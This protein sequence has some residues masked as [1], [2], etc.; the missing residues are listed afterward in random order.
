[1]GH[2]HSHG[3][4]INKKNL[5]V[6]TLL[7]FL[8]S[9]AEI[10]GGL[11]SGSLSLLSDAF[12]NLGDAFSTLIAYIASMVSGKKSTPRRTYGYKRI[13]ILAALLNSLL[14]IGITGYLFIEAYERF[15][16]P[17]E[18]NSK[19]M[20]IVAVIGLVANVLAVFLLR[21]DS[22]HNLNV[23]AAYLHLIGDSLSS[24]VVILGGILI[25]FFN[26]Y[27]VDPFITVII[28]I[29]IL[30][31][32]GKIL[33]ETIKILMQN[34]PPELDIETVKNV[35]EN[36]P[37]VNNV[38]HIHAWNLT[39]QKIYFDAHVDTLNDLSLSE[40]NLVRTDLEKILKHDF[41]VYHVTLQFE[42]RTCEDVMIKQKD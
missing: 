32:A 1:M 24:V 42:Y 8:I 15:R 4:E 11:I 16:D 37:R 36:D 25:F 5:L 18:I 2:N 38:H 13:E 9:I 30:Y 39:D 23:R 14:L 6:A 7:N 35:L 10:I 40:V 17:Q 3:H 26:I 20:L 41:D 27:W 33:N 34:T 19:I 12:H 29:Y 21:G 31:E 22:S 28:G